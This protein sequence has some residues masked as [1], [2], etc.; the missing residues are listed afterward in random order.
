[1]DL[2]S[3]VEPSTTSLTVR[4]DQVRLRRQPVSQVSYYV[5]WAGNGNG[6]ATAGTLRSE[7]FDRM[8]TSLGTRAVTS[9]GIIAV[10]TMFGDEPL[11]AF[12]VTATL[13]NFGLVASRIPLRIAL[14]DGDALPGREQARAAGGR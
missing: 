14:C 1:M 3:S 13:D 5:P 6:D 8:G 2:V 7:A 11:S 9:G 4:V 12:V 10:S